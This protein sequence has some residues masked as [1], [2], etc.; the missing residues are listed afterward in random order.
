MAGG[1]SPAVPQ[2]GTD[3]SLARAAGNLGPRVRHTVDPKVA[4]RTAREFEAMFLSEM[5][6]PVFAHL[7][8]G[9]GTFGGGHGEDTYQAMLVDEYGK[10]MAKHGGIGIAAMVRREILKTQEVAK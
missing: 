9:T 4:D 5:L 6:Q 7:K 3:P 1:S 10:T 8:T 2:L